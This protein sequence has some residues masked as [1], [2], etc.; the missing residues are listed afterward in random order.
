M[1][2]AMLP[3]TSISEV[4]IHVVKDGPLFL[5]ILAFPLLVEEGKR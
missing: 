5:S 1:T 2:A 4:G 3:C